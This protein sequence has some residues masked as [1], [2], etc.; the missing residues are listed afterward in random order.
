MKCAIYLISSNPNIFYTSNQGTGS[1][2]YKNKGKL[3]CKI[4]NIQKNK[5][6]KNQI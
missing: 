5:R 3:N 2:E 1:S 4:R 6:L